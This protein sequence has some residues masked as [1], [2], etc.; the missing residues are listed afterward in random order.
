MPPTTLRALLS[1]AG[2]NPLYAEQ[3]VRMLAER[4]GAE[5]LAV[6]ETVQ[7]I[8]AARLDAL[9]VEEKQLLHDAA[10]LGK[11]FW[12]GAV[13]GGLDR[14]SAA[15]R[16]HALERKDFIRRARR[17]SV[18][19]ES[20][21]AFLHVLVRDVA[22]GQIPRGE[23]AEKHRLA[24]EW[25]ASLGRTEDHAE[26]LAHHYVSALEL[27]RA[28]G[29]AIDAAFAERAFETLRDA[30][31]RAF[32]LHAYAPATRFFQSALEL[33]PAGSADRAH[34]L[35]RLARTRYLA[36]SIETELMEAATV[37][38]MECEDRDTAAQAEAMQSE[39]Y[40]FRGDRDRSLE[41]LDRAL[42]LVRERPPSRAKAYVIS[43]ASGYRMLAGEYPEAIKLA[44]EALAMTRDFGL[45]EMESRALN[46]LGSARV[47]SGD[48]GGIEDLTLSAT[49]A[50][51]ANAPYEICRSRNNLAGVYW[52]R[53]NL[54][55]ANELRAEVDDAV[56][57][58][59]Q[60]AYGRWLR[61][62]LVW[63]KY[64]LGR[65]D[66]ALEAAQETLQEVEAGSP[67]YFA[68][69]CYATRAQILLGRADVAGAFADVDRAIALARR[70]KDPQIIRPVLATSA[71]VFL[72][73]GN[74]DAAA[75][76]V[77][78][79][80]VELRARGLNGDADY[81]PTITWP[82]TVVGRGQ[83]L[84]GLLTGGESPWARAAMAFAGGDLRRAADI[85]RD[86]GAVTEEARDR[87]WLAEI[88]IKEDRRSEAD[89]ELRRAL[90]FYHSV[91][92]IRY[93]RAGEAM[94]A[95]SA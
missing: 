55:R 39:L 91:G 19:D 51:E 73:M 88:L 74:A 2:G 3:Y 9:P 23:R 30:G 44:R 79:L 52:S 75:P 67:H 20:E 87:L 48:S 54:K 82:V 90:A 83:E 6:P 84:L 85:C 35:L 5:Q 41:H 62:G 47:W 89:I 25:I 45:G 29:Q 1:R 16:L 4:H 93:I 21:Y 63:D 60:V 61:G 72:E 40:W 50:T 80:L 65:W 22:Y 57:R 38:L 34:L 70:A 68:S 15:V 36:G 31:E 78:E 11:V 46:N 81:L 56:T 7:G 49:V 69:M 28:A 37:A 8:I 42:E 24:A 27:R 26:M 12:I 43:S 77:D 13:S 92:A 17:S 86:M 71:H 18:A 53:G 14:R 95:A 10:V 58:F 32:S 76:L 94:L 33:A 59:G 66:D 64:A